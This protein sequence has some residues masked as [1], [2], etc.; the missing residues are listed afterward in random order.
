[1]PETPIPAAPPPGDLHLDAGP[2]ARAGIGFCL[3]LLLVNVVAMA[4]LLPGL[5]DLGSS[6]GQDLI[7]G[8]ANPPEPVPALQVVGNVL[9][10]AAALCLLLFLRRTVRNIQAVDPRALDFGVA[11]ATLCWFLPLVNLVAP[12]FVLERTWL[13]AGRLAT[14]AGEREV[15]VVSPVLVWWYSW[16]LQFVCSL[17]SVLLGFRLATTGD[18]DGRW[19]VLAMGGGTVSIA[20]CLLATIRLVR[21][22]Q[23][24]MAAARHRPGA[25]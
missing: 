1:M 9:A 23:E 14:G 19:L 17:A 18:V 10:L 25:A 12:Y 7:D 20:V 24:R 3:A 16:V 15:E 11:W 4:V 5:W 21:G 13:A 8:L 6:S 2:L 22:L